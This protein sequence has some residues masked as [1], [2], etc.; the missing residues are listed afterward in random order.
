MDERFQ[1]ETFFFF[2]NKNLFPWAWSFL[3]CST[4]FK[5]F[6][7]NDDTF[8]VTFLYILIQIWFSKNTILI[9][10]MN[11]IFRMF[12]FVDNVQKLK[13]ITFK[14]LFQILY[15]E[16]YFSPSRW[17]LNKCTYICM[18]YLKVIL[19]IGFQVITHNLYW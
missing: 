1:G 12:Y 4:T 18:K 10:I 8:S 19:V 14:I 2:Q 9:K 15:Y 16:T 6:L 13:N 17:K 5:L 3:V 11:S 7:Q